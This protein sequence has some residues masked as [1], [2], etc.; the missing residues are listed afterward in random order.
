MSLHGNVSATD[1]AKE[2]FKPSKNSAS[3]LVCNEKK[4][5]VFCEWH[6]KWRTFRP[7]WP[8]SS[9]SGPNPL[10]GS[11]LL[12]FLLESRIKAESFDTLDD[13]VVFQVQKLSSKTNKTINPIIG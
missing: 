1:C 3:L 5:W 12:K 2:L 9:D 7:F 11:I 13:L 4:I 6:H 8:T 10:D